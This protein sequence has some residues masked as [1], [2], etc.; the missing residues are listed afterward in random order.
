MKK[1]IL[2]VPN[3]NIPI[4]DDTRCPASHGGLQ[5]ASYKTTNVFISSIKI[6]KC[7]Q[8]IW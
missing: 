4:Y 1:C 2:D 5:G 7:S 6:N 3:V 8:K